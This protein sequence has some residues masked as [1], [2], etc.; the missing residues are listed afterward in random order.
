MPVW[1]TT[2]GVAPV[3]RLAEDVDLPELGVAAHLQGDV[4]RDDDA[5]A[6]DVDASLHV[7][8]RR[9]EAD[10][11]QVERQLADAELVGA[12]RSSVP[13]TT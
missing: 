12:R 5:Q 1:T 3:V 7:R 9:R 4:L 13:A 2:S 6:A 10:V 11:A 8:L